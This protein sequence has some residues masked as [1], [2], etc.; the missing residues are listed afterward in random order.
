MSHDDR[1]NSFVSHLTELRKRLIPLA[2]S[3]IRLDILPLPN[4][5]TTSITTIAICQIPMLIKNLYPF[6]E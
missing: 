6:Y 1:E 3:P 4:S 5:K 2:T